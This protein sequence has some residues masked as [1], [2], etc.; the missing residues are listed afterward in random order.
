MEQL[1]RPVGQLAAVAL[2]A[3]ALCLLAALTVVPVAARLASLREQIEAERAVLGRF[4]QV[5]AQE[6]EAANLD[7]ARRAILASGA[8]LQGES[9]PLIAAGLQSAL[10]EIGAANRVRFTSTRT[11]PPR[12][13]GEGQLIGVRV[14]FNADIEQ[15]RSLLHR[16]ETN[17]PFLFVEALHVQPI[18]PYSQRDPEQ[19]GKLDVRLDVFGATSG[20]K[21]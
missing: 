10:S 9:E 6:H 14:Q 2:L 18:S 1:P 21:G 12:G 16:I 8:Y 19:A 4:A 17:R 11:L 3:L 20:K 13:L 7:R 5:A 15:L